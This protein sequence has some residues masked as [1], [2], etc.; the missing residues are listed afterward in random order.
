ME[1]AAATMKHRKKKRGD[2]YYARLAD[3]GHEAEE[4]IADDWL[5]CIL[6]RNQRNFYT[7]YT[8][9]PHGAARDNDLSVELSRWRA[10]GVLI[11]ALY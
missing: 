3:E 2:D 10:F 1:W 11:M 5:S 4:K 8:Y 7:K 6:S 9:F